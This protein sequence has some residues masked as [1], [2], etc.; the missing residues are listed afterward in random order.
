MPGDGRSWSPLEEYLVTFEEF[1]PDKASSLLEPH[2]ACKNRFPVAS[3]LLHFAVL[4]QNV[5]CVLFFLEQGCDVNEFNRYAET[6]LHWACKLGYTKIVEILLAAGADPSI[7]DGD[8]NTPVHW[9]CEYDHPQVL[10][11][12]LQKSGLE[13]LQMKNVD[14]RTP[15]QEAKFHH[16]HKATRF[17]KCATRPSPWR[18]FT[19]WCCTR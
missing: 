9:A 18:R 10:E 15:E 16:S 3:S 1:S 2:R 11:M 17:L 14:G 5:E 13:T 4:S 7:E 6:P 12:V 19:Y 8:N